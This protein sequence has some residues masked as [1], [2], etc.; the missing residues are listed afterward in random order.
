LLALPF[1]PGGVSRWAHFEA[2][3]DSLVVLVKDSQC[4]RF[5]EPRE[6]SMPVQV[7]KLQLEVTKP[8]LHEAV[9]PWTGALA[10][11]EGYLHPLA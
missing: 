10:A 6:I 4:N 7:A 1:E 11:T 9:L 2:E 8:P 5:M 3:M